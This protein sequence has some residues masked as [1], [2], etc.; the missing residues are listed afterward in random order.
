MIQD[1]KQLQLAAE[2]S[3][4][5]ISKQIANI[6]KILD[7][8]RRD[9]LPSLDGES[10]QL[11][12]TRLKELASV[13]PNV[14]T[15]MIMD[16][17]GVV[18]DSSRMSVL[19][20]SFAY[21][22]YFLAAVKKPA[23]ETLYVSPPFQGIYGDWLIGLSKTIIG[24]TGQFNGVVVILLNAE[25]YSQ[26]LNILDPTVNSWASI[27]HANGVLFAW[28]PSDHAMTGKN[29]SIKGSLFNQHMQSGNTASLF[30]DIVVANNKYSIVAVRTINPINLYMNK[31]LILGIGRNLDGFYP[32]LQKDIWFF[33]SI[34]LMINVIGSI[35]LFVSQRT[36][37][38]ANLKTIKAEA[39]IHK[40]NQQLNNLFDLTPGF[41]LLIDTNSSYRRLNP[42]WQKTLGYSKEEFNN[43]SLFDFIHSEDKNKIHAIVDSLQEGLPQKNILLRLVNKNK[44]LHYLEA[45]FV[46]QK[47]MLFITAL[48][49][50]DRELE[51]D[52]LRSLAYHDR[53]TGLP[54]RTLL[55]DRLSQVIAVDEREKWKSSLIFIDLDGF[56]AINDQ[57]GHDIGDTV[58]QTT[59]NRLKGLVRNVDTVSRYGGDEFVIILHR[60][61]SANDNVIVA[62]KIIDKIGSDIKIS[63]NLVVSV[64]VSIGI[65]IWPDNGSTAE[66]LIDAADR[67]M[68]IS[69]QKGKNTYTLASVN[70]G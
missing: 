47:N 16:N 34:F 51:K 17:E 21:R 36:R 55:F 40:L 62:Q 57:Y 58:L 56:K 54:N 37:M 27:A 32:V 44:Q 67:A 31:P 13:I 19:G 42:I 1:K 43:T 28:E 8:V 26:S 59:A 65:A 20:K 41:M 15:I 61:D 68:Y 52:R 11:K 6:S 9:I 69:K 38:K 63:Q 35:S 60:V 25:D 7:I 64:G 50:T 10:T 49:V 30:S 24:S 70:K 5:V 23:K 39:G 46:L 29:I 48:D 33:S 14:Q 18:T 4:S 66:E 53:L 45:A 3:Q 22:E 12:H 2:A